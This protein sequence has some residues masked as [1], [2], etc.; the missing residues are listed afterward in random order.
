M[1]T[2]SF[3][4]FDSHKFWAFSMMGRGNIMLKKTKG[5][6]F[7]KQF[8]TGERGFSILPDWSEYALLA[9]W[10]SEKAATDF[11]SKSEFYEKYKDRCR[12]IVNYQMDCIRCHGTWDGGTPFIVQKDFPVNSDTKIGVITRASVKPLQLLRFWKYVPKSHEGL[13]TNPGL[14][15]TKGIGDIPLLEMAT[16]SLWQNQESLMNYAY[17]NE[18]H[19]KAISLTKKHNWYS[20]ELFARFAVQSLNLDH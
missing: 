8:G 5:L 18:N 9:V 12:E 17:R 10:D 7:F 19:K 15:F 4:K 20:E 3:F 2:L 16:F 6:R 1:I 14:L 13:F 11:F